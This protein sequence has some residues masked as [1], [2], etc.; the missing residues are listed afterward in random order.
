MTSSWTANLKRTLNT[1]WKGCKPA[2]RT[3]LSWKY[4]QTSMQIETMKTQHTLSCTYNKFVTRI[5]SEIYF[6]CTKYYHHSQY[7]QIQTCSHGTTFAHYRTHSHCKTRSHC[8]IHNNDISYLRT[9][10]SQKSS[11]DTRSSFYKQLHAQILWAIDLVQPHGS[12]IRTDPLI[13]QSKRRHR[14]SHSGT[15]RALVTDLWDRDF[16]ARLI[17]TQTCFIV[18]CLLM[19]FEQQHNVPHQTFQ[20]FPPPLPRAN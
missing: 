4:I 3:T 19:R 11:S 9:P 20:H 16:T 8:Q 15:A 7:T 2:R 17:P 14:I 10:P 13:K 12:H 5:S 1:R 18:I 6:R